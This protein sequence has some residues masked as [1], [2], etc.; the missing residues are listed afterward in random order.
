VKKCMDYEVEGVKPRGSPT[1]AWNNVIKK[2]CQIQQV[3]K[4]DAMD[5]T[6]WTKLIKI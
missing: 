4:K 3:C 2:D 6:E 1:T 5:C